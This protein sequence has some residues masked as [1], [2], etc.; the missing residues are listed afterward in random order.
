ME[1][2]ITTVEAENL[3]LQA[4]VNPLEREIDRL[5]KQIQHV[6]SKDLD[7]A[8]EEIEI[9]KTLSSAG[10]WLTSEQ[11]AHH[12]QMNPV[13]VKHFLAELID[14]KYIQDAYSMDSPVQYLLDDHGNAYLVK[15]NL[16]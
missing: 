9:L 10:R 14:K 1:S 8:S 7:L 12:L 11:L 2:R 16:V 13:R 3:R 5:Q 4:K 15:H 6:E